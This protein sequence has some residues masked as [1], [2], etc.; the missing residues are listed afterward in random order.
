MPF[1]CLFLWLAGSQGP[2]QPAGSAGGRHARNGRA[3]EPSQHH[4]RPGLA[5]HLAGALS[6]SFLLQVRSCRHLA[7]SPLNRFPLWLW[8]EGEDVALLCAERG[9]SDAQRQRWGL[10]TTLQ[11]A[12][13]LGVPSSLQ[14]VIKG[15]SLGALS[16]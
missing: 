15:C 2:P 9:S 5:Q 8:V 10:T 1:P 14:G 16:P 11:A 12:G 13:M 7:L 4:T 6:L 3:G